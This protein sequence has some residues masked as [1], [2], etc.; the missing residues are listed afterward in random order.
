[1]AMK[2]AEAALV[3]AQRLEAEALQ[4]KH[5]EELLQE[6]EAAGD[7]E[8]EGGD[9]DITQII[10]PK[11]AS[12]SADLMSINSE[13]ER[14]K[15][16]HDEEMRRLAESLDA[17]RRRQE[18][19]IRQKAKERR[20]KRLAAMKQRHEEEREE[21]AASG[22]DEE[23]KRLL[24]TRLREVQL[25]EQDEL[26]A[27]EESAALEELSAAARVKDEAREAERSSA[28][29]KY[30]GSLQSLLD[31]LAGARKSLLQHTQEE[32]KSSQEERRRAV[33]V[34]LSQQVAAAATPEEKRVAEA[35]L[36]FELARLAAVEEEESL[37]AQDTVNSSVNAV[38]V[39]LDTCFL[40][41]EVLKA[42]QAHWEEQERLRRALDA[43]KRRQEA[44][45]QAR[46]AGRKGAAHRKR[47][48]QL[49]ELVE[50][51]GRVTPAILLEDGRLAEDV[52]TEVELAERSIREE[53]EQ[54]TRATV[55]DYD[56]E[57]Q[58]VKNQYSN[59]LK[60]HSSRVSLERRRQEAALQKQL[61]KRNIQRR[62]LLLKKRQAESDLKEAEGDTA[63]AEAIRAG[64][65]DAIASMEAAVAVEDASLMTQ[66]KAVSNVMDSRLDVEAQLVRVT[67]EHQKERQSE[68]EAREAER[69]RQIAANRK[70]LEERRAA[71]A[72]RLRKVA[73]EKES[74]EVVSHTLAEIEAE[75]PRAAEESRLEAMAE[76]VD[77]EQAEQQL[78][79]QLNRLK[80]EHEKEAAS[81]KE[82]LNMEARRQ[83]AAIQ[84]RLAEKKKHMAHLRQLR[85]KQLVSCSAWLHLLF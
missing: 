60:D 11:Q 83:K 33:E 65:D 24:A 36:A 37:H 39:D 73:E 64:S 50:A 15:A 47:L 69:R 13:I 82:R 7:E 28:I 84:A 81:A 46:I 10:A 5:A 44:A 6:A 58:K 26:L 56:A 40:D 72:A 29:A 9:E 71:R 43:E 49:Q 31:K 17:E 61:Q 85:A 30:Q 25:Q 16:D 52:D 38:K 8:V 62:A 57:L 42:K 18:A 41:A 21:I 1:M 35:R 53:V 32:I 23:A 59:D 79:L 19:A 45:I 68:W 2:R 54:E 80:A 14:L 34:E 12:N 63:A 78:H 70:R 51:E 76:E 55:Q 75:V 77:N 48:R 74:E 22:V 67:T 3:E 20:E 27:E 4:T 66:L